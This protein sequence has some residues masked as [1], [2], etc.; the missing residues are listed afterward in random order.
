MS[1]YKNKKFIEVY[2]NFMRMFKQEGNVYETI[3]QS[4]EEDYK[5]NTI[6]DD[7]SK[8]VLLNILKDALVDYLVEDIKL[9]NEDEY[10]N[11]ISHYEFIG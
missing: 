1:R 8:L 10:L 6:P 9:L 5:H 4:I 7:M 11:K 2:T 3:K